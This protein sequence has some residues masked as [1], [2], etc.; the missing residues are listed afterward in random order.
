MSPSPFPTRLAE[1]SADHLTRALRPLHPDARVSHLEVVRHAACGDGVASTADRV[2]LRI[3]SS[4]AQV[5]DA[6]VLKTL[7]LH[8]L[9]RFGPA[10]IQALGFTVRAL[11]TLPVGAGVSQAAVFAL[12]NVYQRLFP[13]APAPMYANEVRFY[14]EIRPLLDLEAPQVVGSHF[15]PGSGHFGVLMEDLGRRHA[16]FPNA[17]SSLDLPTLRDLLDGLARLHARFWRAPDLHDQLAWLPT[18]RSGGMHEVFASIG[19]ELIRDQVRANPFKQDLLRPLGRSVD[20]LWHALWKAQDQLADGPQTLLHGDA[21]VG[22]TYT[23]PGGRGGFLDWQ[24]TMRGA[25]AHDVTYLI[26]TA[27]DVPTRRR[28]QRALLAYYLE[29]LAAHGVSDPPD[30]DA[31]FERYR[32]TAVWGLVI[33][34]LITPPQNYGVPIT[35][36]NVERTATACLDL[37]TFEAIGA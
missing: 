5:P 35:A 14:Q 6:L 17:L 36:A 12:V 33:G 4:S 8:P 24:L 2:H 32:R 29:R 26:V 15:D 11:R 34:W 3:R 10:A 23:L 9:F 37:D 31:A 1:L 16:A 19:L 7:L 22:N 18:T 30:A 21:H 13:H 28:E 27:L 20:A 25:W